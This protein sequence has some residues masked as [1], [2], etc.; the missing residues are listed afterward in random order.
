MHNKIIIFIPIINF[1]VIY[2]GIGKITPLGVTDSIGYAIT[3]TLLETLLFRKWIWKLNII[4]KI[5]G[6]ENIQGEWK[7]SLYSNY[8]NKEHVIEKVIIKQSFDKYKVVLETKESKSFSEI[9]KI[10][11]NEFDRLEIEYLYKNEAP[12]NLR[13][14]NPMHFGVAKLE[15]KENELIG[16]YWTDREMESGKNTRGTIVFKN[17][18]KKGNY[19]LISLTELFDVF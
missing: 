1:I 10:K 17:Q 6:I 19:D 2:L 3:L 8:D 4:K 14:Q 16:T 7:G 11:I 13:K 5:T 15:F 9:N 12:V 18:N